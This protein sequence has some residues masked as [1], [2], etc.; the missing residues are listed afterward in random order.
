L[1]RDAVPFNSRGTLTYANGGATSL[2]NFIDDFGG[3]NGSANLTFG[4]PIVRPRYLFQNYFAED[5]WKF[6][7]NLTFSLGVRY[8]NVGTPE[9][10][11]PLPAIDPTTGAADP[12]FFTTPHKQLGDNNNFA[13]RVSFAYTPRFWDGFFGH[14][15]TVIRA[16]YGIYYDNLFTNIVDNS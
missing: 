5:T 9:N 12:N 1:V 7:P 6:R 16:G 13:P 15:K 8:E 3:S 4:S 11:M 14:D 10:S 2:A